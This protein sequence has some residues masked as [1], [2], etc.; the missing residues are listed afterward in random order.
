MEGNDALMY[1]IESF[2]FFFFKVFI[3]AFFFKQ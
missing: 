3:K 1:V 2:F